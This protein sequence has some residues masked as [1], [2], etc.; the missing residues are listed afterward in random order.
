MTAVALRA[1][2]TAPGRAAVVLTLLAAGVVALAVAGL[3][4]G[5][6]TLSPAAVVRG[7]TGGPEAF[8]VQQYRLPRVLVALLAGAAL[9][10]SGALLQAAVRN[11][12]A[13]PDVVGITKGAGLGAMLAAVATP[14]VARV[15]AIPLGVVAGA[16][17]VTV[18]LLVLAR[19]AGSRGAVLALI[20]VAISALA[21]AGIEYLM[22]AF[23]DDADQA[24]VWLAG[25]VYGSTG[26][27]VAVLAVWSLVCLPAVV[28]AVQRMDLAGFD[29]DTVG[30]LGRHPARTR[31]LL[32]T[33]AVALAA[34]AVAA[35]GGIG[36]LGLLAPHLA[37]LLVGPQARV[38]V[39][40]AALIGA[41]LLCLA[42][43]AGRLVALP[44]EIPAGI[45]AAVIGGPYLLVLLIRETRS[46]A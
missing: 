18:V 5:A 17:A 14:P 29:D 1:V 23:P 16:A 40:A 24:M 15:W 31:A 25:S 27:D 6:V 9:A 19:Y 44:N 8:V 20:G 11:P 4:V 30:S 21:A 39:P 33:V 35:V 22:V 43:V 38:L 45:V 26:T 12:L 41:A 3:A 2:R 34:G 37:R 28:V 42:D 13:S 32:V 36:F 10:V 46:H 7:L